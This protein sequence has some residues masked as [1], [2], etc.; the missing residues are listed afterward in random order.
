MQF[1]TGD[2]VVLLVAES[3]DQ[4]PVVAVWTVLLAEI[5]EVTDPYG[6]AINE[7]MASQKILKV[8]V[9]FR[10]GIRLLQLAKHTDFGALLAPLLRNWAKQTW[11]R[12]IAE[13]KFALKM[14]T[15]IAPSIAQA[16]DSDATELKYLA[17]VLL[18]ASGGVAVRIDSG[19][20]GF[21]ESLAS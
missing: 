19:T 8:E 17:G 6:R 4:T 10:A 7:V 9:L 2:I 21:L 1:S 13:Q 11:S 15:V 20:R 14:P 12:V 16:L 18:A 5:N 3:K